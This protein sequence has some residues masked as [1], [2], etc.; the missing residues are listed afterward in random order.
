M[1]LKGLLALLTILIVGVAIIGYTP[2]PEGIHDPYRTQ[3]LM[4]MFKIF[5][6]VHKV[7]EYLGYGKFL[8]T[9]RTFQGKFTLEGDPSSAKYGD[10]Q[11]KR[12]RIANVPVIIY[13]PSTAAELSPAFVYFHGGGWVLG[14]ADDMD[15]VAYHF[16]KATNTVVFN[17]DYRRPPDFPFPV[18]VQDCLEVTRYIL[19]HGNKYGVDVNKVGVGGESAGG[20][21][22]AAVAL[23]ISKEKSDLPPLKFQVL[24]YPALQAFDL[25]L[26]SYVDNNTTMPI[27]SARVMAGFYSLY[28]GLDENKTD[29]YATIIS[30]NR[31]LSP[32]IR[33]SKFSDY[34][35]VKLLPKMFRAPN[36]TA[37]EVTAPFDVN[38]FS[39]IKHIVTN[40]LFSPLM[41]SDLTG[42]PPTFIHAC[43]FD[44]LRDD[45]LLYSKRLQD[46]GVR[47]KMHYGH[48]G[49]HGDTLRFFNDF[50]WVQS[51]RV[52]FTSST[53]FIKSVLRN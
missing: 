27:L 5:N 51:G 21:L 53:D 15:G 50:M 37:S 45:A 10:I 41:S 35:N 7:R 16:A 20:N 22:A 36:K 31:H 46:A 6:F 12:D 1:I 28:M 32:Q 8:N 26:P 34:V 48:G 29:N 44:V 24:T 2:L 18:P 38:V 52:G 11:V 33:E 42:L 25:R 19:R 30:E 23:S 49:F 47:V 17:V 14:T 9:V 13:R 39:K 4:G 3:V 43:E 40:P